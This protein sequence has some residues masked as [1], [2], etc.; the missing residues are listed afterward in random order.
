MVH[1]PLDRLRK[2]SVLVEVERDGSANE[3]I[4]LFVPLRDQLVEGVENSIA[5]VPVA[6]NQLTPITVGLPSVKVRENVGEALLER[7]R[8]WFLS[9]SG[10][11]FVAPSSSKNA[12]SS[13][14]RGTC[15]SVHRTPI[16]FSGAVFIMITC[17]SSV[18]VPG[19]AV[20]RA[21]CQA[22]NCRQP[23]FVSSGNAGALSK[24]GRSNSSEALAELGRS[25]SIS[26]FERAR[27]IVVV[28]VAIDLGSLR[29]VGGHRR[30][31]QRQ[32]GGFQ[33]LLAQLR[34]LRRRQVFALD[35]ATPT[36]FR[37]SSVLAH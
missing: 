35:E 23:V 24:E 26:V 7:G 1:F 4:L 6:V 15:V 11:A 5:V 25:R 33:L 27:G 31:R 3:A 13:L 17:A 30:R 9:L 14:R 16:G 19:A 18:N 12:W 32:V 2:L 28:V 36:R 20:R 8:V 37:S 34:F 29:R 21:M 10:T 22:A